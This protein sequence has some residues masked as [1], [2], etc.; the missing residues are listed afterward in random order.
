MALLLD[1]PFESISIIKN[2]F[3]RPVLESPKEQQLD[4]NITQ[5]GEWIICVFKKR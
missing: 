4:F 3:G 5:S 1:V 2:K